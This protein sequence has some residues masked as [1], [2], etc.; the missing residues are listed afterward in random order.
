MF[1]SLWK[2]AVLILRAAVA[3]SRSAC[4]AGLSPEALQPGGKRRT[5]SAEWEDYGERM[6]SGREDSQQV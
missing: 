6:S 3:V 5:H 1:A 4:P 2:V